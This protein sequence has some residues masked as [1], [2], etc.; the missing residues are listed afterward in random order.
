MA[1]TSASSPAELK[2]LLD[3]LELK[4]LKIA[5]IESPSVVYGSIKK[6]RLDNETK[7][8]ET[9]Y[10]SAEVD[11]SIIITFET[12]RK[13]GVDFFSASN[14]FLTLFKVSYTMKDVDYKDGDITVSN[15]FPELIGK[16]ISDYIILKTDDINVI[17][18]NGSWEDANFDENQKEYITKLK[19]IFTDN[20]S[21]GFECDIDF[22]NFSYER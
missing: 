7:E 9:F 2:S 1:T 11:Q 15:L 21:I 12:G 5:K 18:D 10:K 13:I 16:T 6:E 4:G 19:F 20:T 22:T 17:R 8:Y 14:V 3:E